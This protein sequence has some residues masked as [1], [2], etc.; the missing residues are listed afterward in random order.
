[1]QQF[2]FTQLQNE[3]AEYSQRFGSPVPN[4]A[5]WGANQEKLSQTIQE[6]LRSGKPNKEW[7]ENPDPPDEPPG[8]I[9]RVA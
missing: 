4:W 5:I 7:V 3:I 6:A 2:Q 1:M 8:G 9:T